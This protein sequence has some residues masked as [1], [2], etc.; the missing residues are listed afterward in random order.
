MPLQCL[1]GWWHYIIV[2]RD[3]RFQIFCKMAGEL[4]S[5]A[6]SRK[7]SG[8][9]YFG[10]M[11][12]E[13]K[14][15]TKLFLMGSIIHNDKE[16]TA[17]RKLQLN[18]KDNCMKRSNLVE[19]DNVGR[20]FSRFMHSVTDSCILLQIQAF[21]YWFRHLATDSGILLQIQAYCYWFRHLA[22]DS[23]ILLQI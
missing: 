13:L 11:A 22:T 12:G 21:C 14:S 15:W 20:F 6:K 2:Q 4:K 17:H 7:N 23:G 18:E 10:K 3:F 16:I 9:R 19:E 5:W 1:F 8:F